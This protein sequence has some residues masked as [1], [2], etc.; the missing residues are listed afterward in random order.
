M[1]GPQ[2]KEDC[3]LGG[4]WKRHQLINDQFSSYSIV[5]EHLTQFITLAFLESFFHLASC[6]Y[7]FQLSLAHQSLF[8]SYICQFL[9]LFQTSNVEEPL[10]FFSYP[11]HLL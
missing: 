11:S 3:S 5:K 6:H 2:Y 1:H 10:G 4:G 8:R 9:P 7:T